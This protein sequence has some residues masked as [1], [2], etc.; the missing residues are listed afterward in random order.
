MAKTLIRSRSCLKLRL[1]Q[2]NRKRTQKETMT[3]IP[4]KKRSSRGVIN[5]KKRRR[6]R[7]KWKRLK[8]ASLIER[9]AKIAQLYTHHPVSQKRRWVEKGRRHR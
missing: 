6:N 3:V 8:I 2:E 7:L 9:R 5:R 4:K 1:Q